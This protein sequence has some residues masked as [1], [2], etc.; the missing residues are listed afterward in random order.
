MPRPRDHR[1]LCGFFV[2][3]L[4][5]GVAY[6]LFLL[7]L[8]LLLFLLFLLR[9]LLFILLHIILAFVAVDML[10]RLAWHSCR[11]GGSRSRCCRHRR[12]AAEPLLQGQCEGRGGRVLVTQAMRNCFRPLPPDSQHPL[13]FGWLRSCLRGKSQDR[14]AIR[15]AFP[16]AAAF[17]SQDHVLVA[18]CCYFCF[19]EVQGHLAFPDGKGFGRGAQD[20]TSPMI[21]A[22]QLLN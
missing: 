4:M 11:G 12:R 19:G 10:H 3:L 17:G 14:N 13:L 9:F 2:S 1:Q 16:N 7:F 6:L 8:C 18:E 21:P 15:R 5:A 22:A 20:E